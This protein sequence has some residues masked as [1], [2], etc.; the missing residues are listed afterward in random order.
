MR[1]WLSGQLEMRP[2][3][4]AAAL[5]VHLCEHVLSLKLG[6]L[7][8]AEADLVVLYLLLELLD[9]GGIHNL[10]DALVDLLVELVHD[11]VAD[12]LLGLFG[13]HLAPFLLALLDPILHALV[14]FLF[15]L[16]HFLLGLQGFL[17][18]LLVQPFLLSK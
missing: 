6:Y 16:E 9:C 17:K 15:V 5:D 12:H 2:D 1:I 11:L 8:E 13:L 3:H 18:A 4:D 14:L 10:L 7:L